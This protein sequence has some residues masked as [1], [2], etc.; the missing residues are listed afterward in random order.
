M[1]RNRFVNNGTASGDY[2]GIRTVGGNKNSMDNNNTN[3]EDEYKLYIPT[4]IR[5]RTEL[6]DGFGM[7]ELISSLLTTLPLAAVLYLYKVI[8]GKGNGFFMLGTI[9]IFTATVFIF[10][11]DRTN[12]NVVDYVKNIMIYNRRQ[13]QYIYNKNIEVMISEQ[14]ELAR[15]AE[16][17][18]YS[19]RTDGTGV[20]Q[21][22]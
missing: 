1:A 19:R 10:I 13:H 22:F 8:A 20:H 15:Q 3:N 4:N 17:R 7:R 16:K 18:S 5:I 21:R 11:R 9:I 6:I 14:K 12:Q 2:C